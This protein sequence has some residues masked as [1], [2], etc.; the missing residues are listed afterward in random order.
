MIRRQNGRC[1]P[2][3]N[4]GRSAWQ[5]AA[6]GDAGHANGTWREWMEPVRPNPRGLFA[7]ENTWADAARMARRDNEKH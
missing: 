7:P 5:V 4:H 2:A 3:S 1:W 6:R